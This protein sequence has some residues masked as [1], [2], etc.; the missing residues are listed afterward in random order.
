MRYIIA[1]TLLTFTGCCP[2]IA[3]VSEKRDSVVIEKVVER[4]VSVVD[5]AKTSAYLD[6]LLAYINALPPDTVLQEVVKVRNNGV[7]ASL[8]YDA[9]RKA[10]VLQAR[11]DSVLIA[12]DSVRTVTVNTVKVQTIEK[13]TSWL[14]EFY[15]KFTLITLALVAMYAVY[16]SHKFSFPIK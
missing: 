5:S 2:K 7:S 13:C 16:R 6:S 8:L 14:H 10:V 9:K 3:P 15:R 1:L 11:L 12:R 4:R